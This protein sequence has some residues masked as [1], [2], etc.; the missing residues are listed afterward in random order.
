[1]PALTE[2]ADLHI[3]ADAARHAAPL[4]IPA[5]AEAEAAMNVSLDRT[6]L[7]L[8]GEVHGVRQTPRVIAALVELLDVRALALEWP[9][10]LTSTVDAHRRTGI[11]DDHELLWLGDGRLTPGHLA[12]LCDLAE[13]RPAVEW[14]A[15]DTW[16]IP[17]DMPGES[18]WT[19]RDHAMAR[20]ILDHTSPAGRTLVVA[21]NAH[22]PT[23]RTK[24]GIPMGAWLAEERHGLRSVRINY[25]KGAIY[26]MASKPLASSDQLTSYR[27][28]L[29]D[30]RLL[31][32][33]PS[34][35]EA[36]VP[37]RPNPPVT[38]TT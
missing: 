23:T 12:I 17:P 34:P 28:R 3:L 5:D 19:A 26:N 14:L 24:L 16:E 30:D 13:R 21:G 1:M 22:T 6:G 2:L 36:H 33:H 11:L 27:V 38:S 18:P 25:G 37:H 10:Q 29:H 9:A 32:D 35:E 31:L 4:A 20:R 15:F 7:L 8:L